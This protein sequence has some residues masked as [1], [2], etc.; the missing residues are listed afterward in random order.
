MKRKVLRLL[1]IMLVLLLMSSM[2]ILVNAEDYSE[3]LKTNDDFEYMYIDGGCVYIT[4]YIG[5]SEVVNIP[6]EIDGRTVS[7]VGDRIFLGKDFIKEVNV[8]KTVTSLKYSPAESFLNKS[9][10]VIN[11][12]EENETF[13]SQNGVLFSKDGKVLY[14]YPT[15]KKDVEYTIPDEVTKINTMAFYGNLYLT[16]LTVN[17]SVKSIE[18]FAF[19]NMNSLKELNYAVISNDYSP[20]FIGANELEK[21]YIAREVTSINKYSFTYCPNIVLYVYKDSY[22]EQFAKDNNFNYVII[23][24]DENTLLVDE[25]TKVE[26]YGDIDSDISLSVS[27]LSDD[28]NIGDEFIYIKGYDIS[29]L[30]DG[31]EVK[32]NGTLTVRI[33]YTGS[34]VSDISVYYLQSANSLVDMKAKYL[35]DGYFVFDTDHFSNYILAKTNTNTIVSDE[36][37]KDIET[38]STE[39]LNE[40]S[41]TSSTESLIEDSQI[42]S[43]ESLIEDS[44]ISSN[45]DTSKIEE[46]VISNTPTSNAENSNVNNNIS[47]SDIENSANVPDTGDNSSIVYIFFILSICLCAVFIATKK[48]VKIKNKNN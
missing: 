23:K 21:V 12:D 25:V 44:Q 36:S 29:L 31:Q 41:Q 43:T 6:E 24:E 2:S 33:P 15:A 39:S 37:S 4:R 3:F 42:S 34:D 19:E 13:S 40:D 28:V 22:G 46:S 32:P 14:A 30:K 11:V 17:S 26:A 8:P 9:L 1:S 48:K 16:N 45:D 7:T 38:S 5:N 27:V 47:N 18:Y 10:E 35:D 20:S